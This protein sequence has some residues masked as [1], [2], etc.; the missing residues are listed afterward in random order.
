MGLPLLRGRAFTK[1]EA[2][3]ADAPA[4]AI[5]DEVLARKLWPGGD[6]LG[7]R[8][9]W[10]EPGTPTAAGGGGGTMGISND[11]A[12]G[13]R[14]PQSV[15][16]LGSCPL[17]AGSSSSQKSA[18][19]STC[20][21][22]KDSRATSLR[23]AAPSAPEADAAFLG[24][25]RREIRAAAPG[26]P[27]SPQELSASTSTPARSSRSSDWC[28]NGFHL[29]RSGIG[30]AI[31]GV[32]GVMAYAV[33]RRTR[34]IGVR[35]ALGA[36]P[37][38]ILRMILREGLVMTLVGG[39]LG[40]LLALGIGRAL[41]SM[42][43]EV[44]PLDPVPLPSPLSCLRLSHCSPA[45]SRPTEQ[46]NSIRWW[47]CATNR[48]VGVGPSNIT[49]QTLLDFIADKGGNNSHNFQVAQA[50]LLPSTNKRRKITR[51]T[52]LD[53]Q[54]PIDPRAR[55]EQFLAH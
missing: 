37:G 48:R 39:A 16:M 9:Q 17:P 31:V 22:R 54:T 47:R 7:Q 52:L 20:P 2:E 5:I 44:S 46:P 35:M 26:V 55:V 45:A 30:S 38:E 18:A 32:Y 3:A 13:P 53:S 11:M 14:D 23:C 42:L 49:D 40:V 34:E 15:E 36:S 19:R 12:R 8:I 28:H 4:V 25:I 27:S 43:F 6:A 10:A 24:L 50:S 41:S 21:S 29:W 33:V 1:T 51:N